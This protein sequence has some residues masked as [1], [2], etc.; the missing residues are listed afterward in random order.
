M[1]IEHAASGHWALL[2]NMAVLSPS[3]F[4]MGGWAEDALL[5]HRLTQPHADLDLLVERGQFDMRLEQLGTLGLLEPRASLEPR[6]GRPLDLEAQPGNVPLEIWL[7]D[8]ASGGGY[9]LD[10]PGHPPPSLFRVVLPDDTFQYPGTT[11]EGIAI[12][13]VSPLALYQLRA[14]SALTRSVGEKQARDLAM[15]E[16]LRQAF[17]AE[18]DE[19]R[20][21]PTLLRL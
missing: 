10:L 5:H 12:Q 21:K 7:C 17:L 9:F 6:P 11:I 1:K 4:V 13:T 19:R 3:W 2:K 16:Q 15:Q 8:P 14:V 20:L 18:M